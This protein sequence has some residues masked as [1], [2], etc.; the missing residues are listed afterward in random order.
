MYG[1]AA[2][3][4]R[5]K[6]AAS[7]GDLQQIGARRRVE[8]ITKGGCANRQG[9]VPFSEQESV[10][11]GVPAADENNPDNQVGGRRTGC[12]WPSS[13][14]L[15]MSQERKGQWQSRPLTSERLSATIWVSR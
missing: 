2:T 6:N 1:S 12:T 8:R 5:V 14:P 10:I 15:T 11:D 9:F 3:C 4:R 13:H 7:A